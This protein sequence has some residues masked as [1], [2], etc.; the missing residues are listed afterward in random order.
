MLNDLIYVLLT[1]I[2][3]R[4]YYSI[5]EETEIMYHIQGQMPS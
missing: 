1:K 3:G 4:N 5:D 2:V